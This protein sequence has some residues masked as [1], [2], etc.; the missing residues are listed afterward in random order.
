M[1]NFSLDLHS[2]WRRTLWNFLEILVVENNPI[3]QLILL[4]VGGGSG[5]GLSENRCWLDVIW[6][7]SKYESMQMTVKT[8]SYTL[9]LSLSYSS[10][11][12]LKIPTIVPP[13]P[14]LLTSLALSWF[15]ISASLNSIHIR[16]TVL[17]P[18]IMKANGQLC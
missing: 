17:F 10:E 7:D 18:E 15:I 3:N 2:C 12:R 14:L 6:D 11:L 9:S 16:L 5:L 4:L 13:L 1:F 8:Y